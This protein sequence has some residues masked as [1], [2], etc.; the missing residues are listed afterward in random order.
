MENGKRD[1]G[2]EIKLSTDERA[3]ILEAASSR[4]YVDKITPAIKMLALE[5]ARHIVEDRYKVFMTLSAFEQFSGQLQD[6]ADE[7]NDALKAL[8]K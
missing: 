8:V 1:R 6:E 4:F 2:T 5:N 7:P 3:L